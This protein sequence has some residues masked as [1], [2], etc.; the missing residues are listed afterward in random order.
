MADFVIRFF[1]A[2]VAL[3]IINGV[4]DIVKPFI[5]T[6]PAASFYVYP[7]LLMLLLLVVGCAFECGKVAYFLRP[8]RAGCYEVFSGQ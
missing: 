3:W 5:R 1:W 7:L 4:V 8:S 6:L 2:L